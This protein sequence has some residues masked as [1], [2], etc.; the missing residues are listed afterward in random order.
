[1]TAVRILFHARSRGLF[2]KKITDSRVRRAIVWLVVLKKRKRLSQLT[3]LTGR[4]PARAR[5]AEVPHIKMT[6]VPVEPFGIKKWFLT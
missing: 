1:M 4:F 6:G 2:K 5:A 3:G